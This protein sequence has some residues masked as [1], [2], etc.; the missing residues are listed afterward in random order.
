MPTDES[1]RVSPAMQALIEESEKT[2]QLGIEALR[3]A[4]TH[5]NEAAEM[6]RDAG[7]TLRDASKERMKTLHDIR[8]ARMNDAIVTVIFGLMAG[9][10]VDSL[11]A[12]I[13][14]ATV[15]AVSAGLSLRS[16]NE[17]G[18]NIAEL[19]EAMGGN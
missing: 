14:I 3:K 11:V 1:K 6:F 13:A 2:H 8:K 15:G 17:M 7:A 4:V 10:M 19:K 5:R 12:R 18:N 16:Y 9:I